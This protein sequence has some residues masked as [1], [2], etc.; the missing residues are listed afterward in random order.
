L[1]RGA[2]LVKSVRFLALVLVSNSFSSVVLFF[3]ALSFF[4]LH[5]SQRRSPE[6]ERR[7]SSSVCCSW[8]LFPAKKEVEWP[9]FTSSDFAEKNLP[10][11]LLSE[12]LSL[13]GFFGLLADHQG[14]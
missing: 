6:I 2:A 8:L 1:G 13:G 4:F 14:D 12:T 10:F 3:V 11:L 7:N 9:V 5:T